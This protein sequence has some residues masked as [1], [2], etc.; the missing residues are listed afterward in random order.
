MQQLRAEVIS[1]GDEM[2]TGQR[3][4]TNG[5]WISQRLCDLGVEVAFHSTVGDSITDC[6]SVF[7]NAGERADIVI[8]TGGL[9]P[10][11][12]DLTREALA[13]VADCELDFHEP[14]LRHIESLYKSFGREMPERNKQQAY[15]P[16]GS[17]VIPN[18]EG[19]APGIDFQWQPSPEHATRYFCLPGVPAEMFT[20]FD[21][22][23]GPAVQAM[24]GRDSVIGHY[25]IRTFGRGESSVEEILGDLLSRGRDPRVGITA[26]RATISLRITT[27]GKDRTACMEKMQSTIATIR[28]KLGTLIYG[29][30]EDTI[31]GVLMKL[32]REKNKTIAMIDCGLGGAAWWNLHEAIHLDENLADSATPLGGSKVCESASLPLLE[33]ATNARTEFNSD[34]GVA[35]GAIQPDGEGKQFEL[36]IRSDDFEVSESFTYAGHS[37]FRHVRAVK[38]VL[39]TVRLA[40]L[41]EI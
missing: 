21:Q 5:R 36:A 4:D 20:M 41:G 35:I 25:V 22:T 6:V 30:D 17:N 26:S 28:N 39:N 40:L 27:E 24:T 14:T 23:V 2:T 33:L 11:Q 13:A 12:D 16:A 8:M 1:I 3:L 10:T 34:I 29:S 37:D 18:P 31:P 32:L 15:F 19:T 7:R 38:Q 9:G